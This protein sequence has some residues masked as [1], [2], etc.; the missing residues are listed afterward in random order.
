MYVG[1]K[2]KPKTKLIYSSVTVVEDLV[3]GWL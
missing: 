3:C 1:T 2:Q